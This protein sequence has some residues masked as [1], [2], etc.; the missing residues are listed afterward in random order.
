MVKVDELEEA[1]ASIVQLVS[2]IVLARENLSL[3]ANQLRRLGKLFLKHQGTHLFCV[4]VVII[5]VD[6]NSE[7]VDII[8]EIYQGEEVLIECL[9]YFKDETFV[10]VC[11]V[12]CGFDGMNYTTSDF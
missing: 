6:N 11:K 4:H 8:I 1:K 2:E 5:F 9:H 12:L 3:V 7:L 10:D